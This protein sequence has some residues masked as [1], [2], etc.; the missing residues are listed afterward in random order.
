M[1]LS[2]AKSSHLSL[3]VAVTLF[4]AMDL[5]VLGI[6][7][8]I[9]WRVD[10]DALVINLAGR[11]RMLTQRIP[12]ALLLLQ[13]APD[14]ETEQ[15][16]LHEL[17]ESTRLFT[18]TLKAFRVGGWVTRGDGRM[19]TIPPLD[20][21]AVRRLLDAM[22]TQWDAIERP[23][24]LLS[25]PAPELPRPSFESVAQVA[26]MHTPALLDIAN[27]LTTHIQARSMQLTRNLRAI[28]TLAF[29]LALV[30][31]LIILRLLR[32]RYLLAMQGQESLR[33]LIDQIGAGVCL[34]NEKGEIIAANK[35]A[36]VL[37]G[38][39]PE[40]LRGIR[41]EHLLTREEN[42]W[43]S[44]LPTGRVKAIDVV[45]G[46]FR[47]PSAHRS[48]QAPRTRGSL[49]TL[50]DVSSRHTERNLL[51]HL[52][53]HDALTG[54]PNRRLL[55]DRTEQALAQARR[56]HSK[57]GVALLDL[58]DFK[59]INDLY[60]HAVGD[61]ILRQ[62]AER[63]SAAV[64]EV[65]T[66][67]R[68]GGDEFVGL[69]PGPIEEDELSNL[70]ARLSACFQEP[71]DAYGQQIMMHASIGLA[72]YPAHGGTVEALLIAADQAMY[73]SKHRQVSPEC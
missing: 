55:Y 6:N 46:D 47:D 15:H 67:A 13:A 51:R 16:A 50:L 2:N 72:E 44:R 68:V 39:A 69:F 59:P 43:V 11:Q 25:H 56:A 28:Q 9:V 53:N 65:D 58:D 18:E 64:R 60:G 7:Y 61:L 71:F 34:L 4:V 37:V 30:N 23:V 5:V 22:Q 27:Q 32:R 29:G 24:T 49:V 63:L 40:H 62:V 3:V 66:L 45:Y 41:F 20:G 33:Q 36:G 21:R 26:F 10:R 14:G 73:K 70:A 38:R 19:T 48:T 17:N 42:V 52:A 1:L 54:L 31:F 12:K 35:A 8:G 57:V